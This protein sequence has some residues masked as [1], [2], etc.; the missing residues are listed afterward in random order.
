MSELEAVV[1]AQA[2]E[3]NTGLIV[4]SDSFMSGHGKE[5]T[6][7]AARYRLPDRLSVPFLHRT[8]WPAVLRK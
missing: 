8:R 7:L 5:I 1:A 3:A 2:R 4:M 6:S